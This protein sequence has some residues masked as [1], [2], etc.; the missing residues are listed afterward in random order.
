MMVHPIPMILEAGL[1]YIQMNRPQMVGSKPIYT[2]RQIEFNLD[3][4]SV[5]T[6]RVDCKPFIPILMEGWLQW[7]SNIKGVPKSS[8]N[9]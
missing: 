7:A 6:L 9:K 3:F 4:T 8:Q 1:F 2:T 5:S